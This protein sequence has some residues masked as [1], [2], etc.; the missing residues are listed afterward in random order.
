MSTSDDHTRNVVSACSREVVHLWVWTSRKQWRKDPELIHLTNFM[1]RKG[2]VGKLDRWNSLRP[3][4]RQARVWARIHLLPRDYRAQRTTESE[5]A[6]ALFGFDCWKNSAIQ[7][8]Q[9]ITALEHNSIPMMIEIT[10]L[11]F[12]R[13][14]GHPTGGWCSTCPIYDRHGSWQSAWCSMCDGPAE[15]CVHCLCRKQGSIMKF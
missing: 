7:C 12:C 1:I 5:V 13:G 10:F 11:P 9:S 14:C 4:A 6:R 2:Y 8:L 3:L 15:A